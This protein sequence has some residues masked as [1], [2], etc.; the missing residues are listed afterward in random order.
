MAG[1]TGK[2]LHLV[3]ASHLHTVRIVAK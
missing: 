2:T 3:I 1:N